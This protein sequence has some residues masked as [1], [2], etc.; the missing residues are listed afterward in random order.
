[1]VR[2]ST[3][4]RDSDNDKLCRKCG[5]ENI[6]KYK[7]QVWLGCSKK[8]CNYWVHAVCVNVIVKKEEHTKNIDYYCDEHIKTFL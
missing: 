5:R 8:P 3:K 1:R 7:K 6:G 4:K 2:S